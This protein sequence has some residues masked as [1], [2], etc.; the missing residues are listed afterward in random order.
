MVQMKRRLALTV[1]F[2]VNCDKGK[3]A[4]AAECDTE[5]RKLSF[6]SRPSS[7]C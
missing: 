6:E 2:A 1:C 4:A 7:C 5:E 3:D